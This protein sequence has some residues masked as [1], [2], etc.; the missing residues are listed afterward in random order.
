M[1]KGRMRILPAILTS[2]PADLERKIRQ[3]EPLSDWVQ[4]DIM[5]GRFV[6]SRSIEASHLTSINT[7]LNMEIHL[8]TERPEG[9]LD[10]FARAGAKRVLFHY[11]ATSSPDT[12]VKAAR[13]LGLAVGIA[14]NPETPVTALLKLKEPVDC[15]L[16]LS[17]NPGFYGREF[18][19]AVLDK[20][21][22]FRSLR[23]KVEVGID[24]GIKRSNIKVV[25]AAGVDYACVG[26]EIFN[27]VAPKEAYMALLGLVKDG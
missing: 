20:V 1:Q 5:D 13:Q 14:L 19:P 21:R 27:H 22:E 6:P 18:I 24:G 11:E 10:G 12:V 25:K 2:D 4:I 17:V 9:L 26:S 3:A 8:M 7:E 16:F 15:V 23:A